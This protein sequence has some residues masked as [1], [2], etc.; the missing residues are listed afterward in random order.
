AAALESDVI[1]TCTPSKKF[2]LRREHVRPG[3]FVAAVGA[4][5]PEKQEIDPQLFAGNKVVADILSQCA[6]IGDLHHAL[7]AHTI[8]QSQVH[9][10]LGE[11]VA[12]KK[13]GRTTPREITI[14]D[15][16]GTAIE[17]IA[18]AIVVYRKALQRGVGMKVNLAA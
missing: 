4:D 3:T 1:V 14:F 2:F 7:N 6:E 9:A 5:N 11:L 12:N 17:D 18:A 10:E 15:S 8:T 13:A 16:T